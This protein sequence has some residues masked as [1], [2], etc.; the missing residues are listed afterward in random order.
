M[1]VVGRTQI[2]RTPHVGGLPCIKLQDVVRDC[3]EQ[4]PGQEIRRSRN[5]SEFPELNLRAEGRLKF[6]FTGIGANLPTS[7]VT[8]VPCIRSFFHHRASG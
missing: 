4:L 3:Y 2:R 6:S 8:T 7:Q 1:F 5:S